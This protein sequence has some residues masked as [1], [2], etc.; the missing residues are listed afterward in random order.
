MRARPIHPGTRVKITRC[1]LDKR[2]FLALGK[3]PAELENLFGYVLGLA[4]EKYGAQL[5]AAIQM[6]NHVHIDITDV[7][8]DRPGFKGYVFA[9]LARAINARHGR[10]G[11]FWD[12]DGSCDTCQP[13]D[14]ESFEDLAYTE[15][16]PVEAGLVKW[17]ERWEGFTTF[18][19][20]FGETRTYKRPD[21]FFDP[22]NPERPDTITIER[23]RPNIFPELSDDELYQR[24]QDRVRERS[25]AKQ[26]ELQ[27]KRR[28]FKGEERLR[29]ETWGRELP[30]AADADHFEVKPKV[31]ASS[32]RRKRVQL[33]RDREWERQYAE[34]REKHRRG[35][36]AVFPAGTYKLRLH[37]GVAVAQA[38]P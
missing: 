3:N 1:C 7:R 21:W 32:E 23:V 38:P 20:E 27:K 9:M 30:S 8:G 26:N 37:H 17:A 24:L 28:R 4:L 2:L 34:A 12:A 19:W 14:E 15:V 6:G 5:H 13:D 22:D 35:E 36:H 18:G 11:K 25:V 10:K 31:V 16:N 33:Q 29:N